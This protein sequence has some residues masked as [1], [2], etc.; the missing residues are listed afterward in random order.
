MKAQSALEFVGSLA[1]FLGAVGGLFVTTLDEV[2]QFNQNAEQASLYQEAQ[3]V[4]GTL[5]NTPGET[6]SGGTNWE[7]TGIVEEPGLS[8]GNGK[9]IVDEDKLEAFLGPDYQYR[10]FTEQYDLDSEFSL[11]FTHYPLVLTEKSFIRGRPPENPDIVEPVDP[12]PDYDSADNSV[13]YGSITIDGDTE[14]FLIASHDSRFDTVYVANYDWNFASSDPRK[15]GDTVRFNDK[16]Y[17]L[18]KI[19]N[20]DNEPG[21]ML[22]LRRNYGHFGRSPKAAEFPAAKITRHA[23]VRDESSLEPLKV[24]VLNW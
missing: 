1:V 23:L 13:H 16:I 6:T 15:V 3:A 2:P 11:N 18:E 17:E 5:L 7:N 20:R 21:T 22:V 8:T 10:N 12:N 19:A 9:L 24:E 4:S 14:Q